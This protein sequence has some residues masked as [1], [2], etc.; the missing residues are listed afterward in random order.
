MSPF[1]LAFLLMLA[2]FLLLF[3]AASARAIWLRGA[4]TRQAFR[5]W[6]RRKSIHHPAHI[7]VVCPGPL[8]QH[9]TAWR[10]TGDDQGPRLWDDLCNHGPDLDGNVCAR[11]A[12]SCGGRDNLLEPRSHCRS[13]RVQIAPKN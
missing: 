11:C 3:L 10:R 12:R 2:A 9:G 4:T 8:L 5:D 7:R 1:F 13:P 6:G